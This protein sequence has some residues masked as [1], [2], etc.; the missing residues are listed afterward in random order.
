MIDTV[1]VDVF[2]Q[3]GGSAILMHDVGDWLVPDGDGPLHR[4]PA[5]SGSSTTSPPCT[6]PTGDWEDD[7]GL[8]ALDGRYA[9][10]AR[11]SW[12]GRRP[13]PTRRSSPGSP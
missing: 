11:R 2:A 13:A 4:R 10:F 3:P 5:P 9:W 1:V 7:L 6:P 8:L 12:R